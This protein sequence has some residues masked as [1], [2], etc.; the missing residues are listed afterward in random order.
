M[1]A[2]VPVARRAG[3]L[4]EFGKLGAFLRRDL[5][6]A[7]SYRSAFLSDLVALIAQ[8]VLFYFVG[9]MVDPTNMPHYGGTRTSYMAF[10][11]VG[12]AITSLLHVGVGRMIPVLRNDIGRPH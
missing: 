9:L 1:N 8:A 4:Q 11:V 3:V 10:V 6:I 7:W 12:I 5:L 2:A